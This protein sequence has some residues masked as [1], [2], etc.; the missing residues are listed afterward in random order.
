M[1]T[2]SILEKTNSITKNVGSQA[3]SA[4]LSE[5]DIHNS[6]I[7]ENYAK[8]IDPEY[9][10]KDLLRSKREAEM[11]AREEEKKADIFDICEVS[12]SSKPETEEASVEK[13]AE[14]NFDE[15]YFV[16]NAR[17]NSYIF[18]ADSEVNSRLRADVQ[19]KRSVTAP[20]A[21]SS[22]SDEENEDLVP[23][24]TTI[25]YKTEKESA[26]TVA[27]GRIQNEQRRAKSLAISKKE[28]L[29]IAGVI[30][31]IIA[32]FVLI[33]VNSAIIANLKEDVAT[34]SDTYTEAQVAYEQVVKENNDY[35]EEDNLYQTVS[36]FAKQ[37]GMVKK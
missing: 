28:K 20:V 19:F 35:F 13:K 18:R 4:I 11:R 34:L 29:T 12:N 23:T 9:S 36:E 16:K 21:A 25:Q 14:V 1:P 3:N 30:T 37:N 26:V 7:S 10:A 24:R 15:P 2:S 6:C 22:V 8:L 27:E 31:M 5:D 17:A 33:I 32:L